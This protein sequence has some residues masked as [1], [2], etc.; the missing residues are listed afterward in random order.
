[1][2]LSLSPTPP[3]T[4]APT[5]VITSTR[6]RPPPT[7]D[8]PIAGTVNRPDIGPD[9]RASS[10]SIRRPDTSNVANGPNG[11]GCGDH[12]T[13]V[14]G[15]SQDDAY[16]CMCN[17]KYEGDNC[18][19]EPSKAPSSGTDMT[20]VTVAGII[21]GVVVVV[22]GAVLIYKLK[23][24]AAGGAASYSGMQNTELDE[25]SSTGMQK[26]RY[27]QQAMSAYED[28]GSLPQSVANPM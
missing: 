10:G 19:I 28:I 13:R 5:Q 16:T 27:P 23:K 15:H 11:R 14:D 22:I 24:P 25:A 9:G 2:P 1:M 4:P 18:E 26:P 12:G 20:T 3:P 7:I 21:A 8:R 17:S 6:S